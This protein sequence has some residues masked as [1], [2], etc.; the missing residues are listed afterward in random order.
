MLVGGLPF[1][2][3]LPIDQ[4]V[5]PS[6]ING[7]VA[8][9]VTSDD[10]PLNGNVVQRGSN[11]IVAGPL[12]TFIDSQS[13]TLGQMVHSNGAAGAPPPSTTIVPPAQ[14]SALL[15]SLGSTPTGTPSTPPTNGT[16]NA[17]NGNPVI[18]NGISMV[19]VPTSTPTPT[20]GSGSGS[21]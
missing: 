8:I 14:A 2:I 12:L 15:S 11:A 1:S 3:S 20:P 17:S 21:Y 19:P 10:Q 9:W 5:V 18:A 13:E 4:C 16:N 6:G 7:A